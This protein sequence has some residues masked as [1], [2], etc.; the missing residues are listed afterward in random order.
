MPDAECPPP[1]LF[2]RAE[3]LQKLSAVQVSEAEMKLLYTTAKLGTGERMYHS[4][5]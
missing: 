5:E 3:L 4:R 1:R 2:Q